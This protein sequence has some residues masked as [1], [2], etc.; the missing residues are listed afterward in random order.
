MSLILSDWMIN[1]RT[2]LQKWSSQPRQAL[3]RVGANALYFG[4]AGT[5]L[6]PIAEAVGRGDLAALFLLNS[7]GVNV[8]VNLI[9]NAVQDWADEE[10]AARQ[11]AAEAAE[12][13]ELITALDAILQ[14]VEAVETVQA[15]L[16]QD[17]RAWFVE[18]LR[19]EVKQVGSVINV[20]GGINVDAQEVHV[21]GD[22]VG[23]DKVTTHNETLT[24]NGGSVLLSNSTVHG[25][26][27]IGAPQTSAP[28]PP[29]PD[30]RDKLNA[31]LGWVLTQA[32]NVPLAGIDR[33]SVSEET[34]ADLDL[35][36]VYTELLTQRSENDEMQRALRQPDREARRLSALAVLNTEK[37]LALLGDPGSGKSTFVN[38]LTMCLAGERLGHEAVNLMVLTAPLP[39]DEARQRDQK[40]QPQPQPWDHGT[41]LP[42]RVVLRDLAARGLPSIG[43]P[44][45]A[46]C[47]WVFILREFPATLA[48]CHEALRDELRQHGGLLLLDGLD[49]I[50]EAT[51]R[52][53]Q[54]KAVVAGFVG[55]FPKVRVLVTS[56]TYAY[57]KQAWKLD[58]FAEAV[59][60]PFERGQ[61]Q[62]FVQRWYTHVGSARHLSADDA[63]GRAAILIAAIERNPRLAELAAR[64]LLLTLM[65]SLHA[66]RGGTL[67]DQREELYADA[68]DLLLD[69]WEGQKVRRKPDGQPEVIEPSLVE[70]LNADR[71][72]VRAVLNHLAFDAHRQQD[73]LTGTADIAQDKLV[74]ELLSLTTSADA[75]PKRLIE[76]LSNR[77]GL[78]E[79]R[80]VGMYAFPHRTF[81]EYLAACH[82]TDHGYPDDLAELLRAD[83]NRWREVVL[84]AGAKATRGTA[85]AAWLLAEALCYTDCPSEQI[86]T[87]LAEPGAWGALLAAQVLIENN[88]LAKIAPRNQ[89]KVER[90]RCWLTETL[91]RG[92]L[93]PVDRVEAGRAL[94]AI[95]DPR[96]LEA[97][98]EI[99][100]G[101]FWMG[102][103]TNRHSFINNTPRHEVDLGTYRIGK[104][105]VTVG[106]WKQFIAATNYSGSPRAVNDPD[107]HPVRYVSWHGAIAYCQWLTIA[108]RANSKIAAN[109]VAH[110]P[111]EAEWE[112]AA[113]GTDRR[114]YPWGNEFEPDRAN[115]SE[116]GVSTTSAVGCFPRGA[117]P[118]GGLDMAGNVWEWVQ[119]KD[120]KY[121]Y[122]ADDGREDLSDKTAARVVRGGSWSGGRDLVRCAFRFNH[123]PGYRSGNYGFR[124]LLSPGF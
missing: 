118:Y 86:S 20:S 32:R 67:P 73:N 51:E 117:S 52:R 81:Q 26:I 97:L 96:D 37:Y 61:I 62:R 48:D 64:P 103:E 75:R 36:A 38:F 44:V 5:A 13:Q 34:R 50:S 95:G 124:I 77:A 31:Y 22:V 18:T 63:Q 119:S 72:Q 6:Y 123:R 85:A 4:M 21:G 102:D 45:P 101:K 53:E 70:W 94:S 104:Y 109:D 98:I 99:P 82:L 23:R 120:S 89:E 60:A 78:L 93:P 41:L 65:A 40:K 8:G 111:T 46:D 27:Q 33:K 29:Q 74:S 49:E 11:L 35:A 2:R 84:L 39:E 43:Q 28:Q 106:Q 56:R 47:L 112:K 30:V 66:W 113:R 115:T 116:L 107:N 3:N 122:R 105:P 1:A 59:L 7:L 69:Q 68:V 71:E 14:K 108:W 42:L 58:N 91:T 114:E 79:P 55:L 88:Q 90:I 16:T 25:N 54:V 92:W 121:P 15:G 19:A 100:A 110:L 24:A 83:P 10:D 57:Q 80:G 17:D 9:A 76:Y 12:H 87:K